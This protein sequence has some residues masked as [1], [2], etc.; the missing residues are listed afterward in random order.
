MTCGHEWGEIRKLKAQ[1]PNEY[2]VV[3]KREYDK[4]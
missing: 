4:P 3:E 1:G 2:E